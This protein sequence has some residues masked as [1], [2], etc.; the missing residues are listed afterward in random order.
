MALRSVIVDDEPAARGLLAEILGAIGDVDVVASCGDG[1]SAIEAVRAH[2]PDVVFLDVQMPRGSGF[3]VLEALEDE[4]P[5]AVVFVT[6]YDEFAVQA[7]DASA[8]DYL[9][10]PLD[11]Q[12][13]RRAVDRAAARVRLAA[14]GAPPGCRGC[15]GRTP[16][17]RPRASRRSWRRCG[18]ASPTCAGSRSAWAS[19]SC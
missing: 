6:A 18:R 13:V 14:A 9:L 1:Q 8:A 19:G 15:P 4:A 7:F 3:E 5:P 10:K 11:E 12:R 2:R 16:A 17:P